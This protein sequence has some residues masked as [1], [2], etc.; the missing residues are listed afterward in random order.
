MTMKRFEHQD[1]FHLEVFFF[2]NHVSR[3]LSNRRGVV[4]QQLQEQ[5]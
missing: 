5:M 2:F 3:H 1:L 4:R